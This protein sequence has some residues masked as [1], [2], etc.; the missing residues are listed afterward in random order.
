VGAD[1]SESAGFEADDDSLPSGLCRNFDLGIS[2]GSGLS[3]SADRRALAANEAPDDRMYSEY[4][5]TPEGAQTAEPAREE[6]VRAR[7]P[8]V[9]GFKIL[10]E[11]GRGA[12]GVVYKA[13]QIRLN[14]DVALK[15]ILAGDHAS[16]DVH[17]RFHAEAETI[18]RLKHPNI[19]QI[20][21]IGDCDGRPYVELELVEG[22]S[23]AARLD[24][25]P[26][27]PRTAAPLIENIA[28]AVAE[29]HRLG[30]VHRDLKPGNILMTTEGAPKVSDFGLAK[31]LEGDAR[32][33]RTESILGSPSYMAPEQAGGRAKDVGPAADV[34][35][36]GGCLYELLTG[37]PPF[38]GPTILATLEMVKNAD[39]V[40]PRR[41]QPNLARDLETICLKCLEKEPQRRYES[42]DALADDLA[43]YLN[44]SPIKARPTPQWERTVK[45]I[46]RRPTTAA[47]V[48]VSTLAVLSALGGLQAYRADHLRQEEIV[49][50]RIARV[51]GQSE[52]FVL[53]GKEAVRRQDWEAARNQF[54]SAMALIRSEPR[55][56]DSLAEVKPLLSESN[57]RISELR[58]REISRA[59]LSSF[60]GLYD[61]AV[62]HES[63]YT[64]LDSQANLQ[65]G[66]SA[67]RRALAIFG[68]EQATED[69]PFLD[70]AHFDPAEREAITSSCYELTLILAGAVSQPL[71][72]EDPLAQAREALRVLDG[73]ERLRPPTPPV[74]L[75]R[76]SYLERLGESDAAARERQ[77]A[78]TASVSNAASIDDFLSGEDALRKGDLDR[79]IRSFQRALMSR[80]DH[81]WAQYLL[82]VC[83]LQAHRPSEAQASLIACQSRRPGFV[84]TYLLKGFAEGEMREFDLAE[85]DFQR[86]TD[87]GLNDQARYVMLV[88]RGVMRIRRGRNQAATEDLAAAI[89]LKPSQFQA[90]INLAQAFENLEH[91]DKAQAALDQAI[92]QAPG[93]AVLHRARGQLHKLRSRSEQALQ[94][95]GQAIA[96]APAD[97]PSLVSDL[98]ERGL[99]FQQTGRFEEAMAAC[100]QALVLRPE[101]VDVQRLRGSLLLGLKRFPEAVAAFDICLARGTPSPALY[102]ARG[103]ALTWSG[104]YARAVSD[105]T[106]A[107]RTGRPTPSLLATRGWAYLFSGAPGPAVLDFDE[108]MRK[109]PSNSH[110]LGGRALAQ[111]Q[112]RKPGEAVK[113]A[114]ASVRLSPRDPRQLYSAARILCQAAVCV[115]SDPKRADGGWAASERYRTEALELL[116]VAIDLTPEKGRA[117]FLDGVVRPDSALDPI[118]RTPRFI[119]LQTRMTHHA[120]AH[121]AGESR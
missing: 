106:M 15:M 36:L 4:W 49:R 12:M 51:R 58:D 8:E 105:L 16:A 93:Q 55:L 68:L 74:F 82:A 88:N 112:L 102:E 35:A 3:S 96:L 26:W 89:A 87:L 83:Q 73:I 60:Q 39:P 77:R 40:S 70:P 43:S 18:A 7:V 31:S 45:W 23:L 72:G 62:F 71:A 76:A 38:V 90:Y 86:A 79:A 117:R 91:W 118:R 10:G 75:R 109:D 66:R 81:F 20:Y 2:D 48:G 120:S 94:D 113:D 116:T 6:P 17:E 99:I 78:E 9:S 21:G 97:D 53:I 19:V 103:M 108:V 37:R 52:Q 30:I 110:A 121:P 95:L 50:Q 98:L 107:L 111:I 5:S 56:S 67:A 54:S 44:H 34:Y 46:R 59:R 13:R 47:L 28:R 114:R 84:W 32:L 61:E 33:T 11:L 101:R 27:P 100:D 1:V 119:S 63:N 14:R 64:G 57:Q 104:S 29:A 69:D 115:E 25:T 42:A 24:G 41:L 85:A 80:P 92:E 65:A 22:G